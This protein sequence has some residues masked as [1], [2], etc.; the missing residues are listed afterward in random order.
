MPKRRE[1]SQVVS[2]FHSLEGFQYKL[3]NLPQ[4]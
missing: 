1:D 3:M 2:V 4:R